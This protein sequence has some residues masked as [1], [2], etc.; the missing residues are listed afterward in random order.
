MRAVLEVPYGWALLLAAPV[1]GAI[2]GGALALGTWG[3]GEPSPGDIAPDIL[4]FGL[5]AQIPAFAVAVLPRTWWGFALALS[6][7]II[8]AGMI[9]YDINALSAASPGMLLFGALAVEV[10][11]ILGVLII[12][13]GA[14]TYQRMGERPEA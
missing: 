3:G 11:P 6:V 10:P 4:M 13:A 14:R 9:V 2:G 1:V 7:L 5:V 12:E 8:G